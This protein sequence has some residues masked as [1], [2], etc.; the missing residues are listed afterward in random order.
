MDRRELLIGAAALAAAPAWSAEKGFVKLYNGKDLT[1]WHVQEGKLS[2]WRANGDM[3]TCEP[4]GGFLTLDRQYGDFELRLEYRIPKGGNSGIGVHYP[5]GGHPS[6]A[7]IEIQI[8]DDDAPEHKNIKA[9]QYNGSIYKHIPPKTKAPNPLNEWNK[10][11]VR[12]K[13][14]KLMV[15]LNGVTIQDVNCEEHTTA[16]AGYTPLAKLPRTGCVGIQSHSGTV[17]F[18]NLEIREL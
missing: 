3:I 14:P 5:P 17:D 10:L 16:E 1:G 4:G 15:R 7:A 12:L 18:R 11:V 9:T 6:S 2:A 13:W 8:L